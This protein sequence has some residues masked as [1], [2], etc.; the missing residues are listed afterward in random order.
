MLGGGVFGMEGEFTLVE[1]VDFQTCSDTIFQII[2][3]KSLSRFYD[4]CLPKVW[5]AQIMQLNT[6]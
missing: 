3:L 2:D 6:A 1:N 5:T 4:W